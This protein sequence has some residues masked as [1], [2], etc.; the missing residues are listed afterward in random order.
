VIIPSSPP[1]SPVHFIDYEYAVPCPPAFDLA[2]HFSEWAGFDCDYTL[3]PTRQIRREFIR[4]YLRSY[5]QYAGTEVELMVAIDRYRGMP[6]FYWGVQA[7][8]QAD[9]SRVE[10]DWT[11]YA[12]RRLEEYW[13]WRR[14]EEGMR[15]E[16]MAL[17]ERRWAE[18]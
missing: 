11:K 2:N 9:I 8:I 14:G 6:G 15:G 16:E 1:S 13:A 17:R 4:E 18:E 3:L 7:L 12:Q 5:S 10:F